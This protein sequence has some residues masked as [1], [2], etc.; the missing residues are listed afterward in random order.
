MKAIYIGSG[1]D[2][3][4]I[5][6]LNHIKD[7]VYIDCK[8]FSEFG[9]RVH[10]CDT[11]WCSKKCL[12]FKR[13]WVLIDTAGIRRRGKIGRSIEKYSVLRAVRSIDRAD[14]CVLVLDAE[15]MVATQDAHIGGAIV[16]ARRA[17]VVVVNKWDLVS[18]GPLAGDD[19]RRKV[20][21][22]MKHLTWAPVV[23]TSALTGR[24][25]SSPQAS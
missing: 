12:G 13:P 20:R 5:V 6:F 3:N 25:R 2:V 7:W 23:F 1:W 4:P 11:R 19:F 21:E 17:C 8:P 10:K 18:S 15:E 14:V 24:G 16:D 22:E 9:V